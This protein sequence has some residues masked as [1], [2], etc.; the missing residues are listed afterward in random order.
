[1]ANSAGMVMVMGCVIGIFNAI[2]GGALILVGFG[3]ILGST[4]G[5]SSST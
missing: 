4:Y 5:G 2:V 1:M 3:M